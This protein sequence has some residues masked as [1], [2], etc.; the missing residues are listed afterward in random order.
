MEIIEPKDKWFLQ[1]HGKFTAS[2]IGKLL[3]KGAG[4]K[5]FGTGAITYIKQK[6]IEKMT[7]LWE[8]PE[9]DEV[10]SLLHG[11]VHEQPAYE[12]YK[13]V[14][15]NY[16]MRYFGTD[17]PLF[18]EHDADSGGSPDGLMGEGAKIYCG[19]ELKCPK[20]SHIHWD[21]FKM[22]D[23]WDLK[24][25]NVDYYSQI[26][27]LMHMTS[28][29]EFHFFSYDDRFIDEKK[30]SKI[31][32]VLPDKKFMDNLLIRIQMAVKMRNEIIEEQIS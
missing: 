29:D 21:Y 23:Q 10:K 2:E 15:K 26:Q 31:I 9:L 7:V 18:L 1:R 12:M 11:K 17:T 8:R 5:M 3:S 16:S 4:T 30:K 14:T 22:K 19:L 6:A 25:Y 24:E 28:A 13:K 20:N 32:T 27:F